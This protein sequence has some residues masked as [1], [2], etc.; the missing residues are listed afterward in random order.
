MAQLLSDALI[1]AYKSKAPEVRKAKWHMAKLTDALGAVITARLPHRDD[2]EREIKL[3]QMQHS[4][5]YMVRVCDA[6]D[7]LLKDFPFS[8]FIN[9]VNK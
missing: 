5:D 7:R 6:K 2:P 1:E 8:W 3:V 4:Y 9:K